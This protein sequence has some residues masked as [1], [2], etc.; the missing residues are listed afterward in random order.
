M[1]LTLKEHTSDRGN[2]WHCTRWTK[3]SLI[4]LITEQI[5]NSEPQSDR[6]SL[7]L[8]KSSSGRMQMGYF[9]LLRNPDWHSDSLGYKN[10]HPINQFGLVNQ[11]LQWNARQKGN[12]E[13]GPWWRNSARKQASGSKSPSCASFDDASFFR[14]LWKWHSTRHTVAV[15]C[16]LDLMGAN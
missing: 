15:Q 12:N 11:T 2:T 9:V 5:T 4:H 10:K 16:V 1:E 7:L 8:S 13:K 6:T 14:P 3:A